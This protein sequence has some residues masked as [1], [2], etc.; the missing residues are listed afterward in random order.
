MAWTTEEARQVKQIL[1]TGATTAADVKTC[2]GE[3]AD[4]RL[5]LHGRPGNG[6]SPGLITRVG[7]NETAIRNVH[8]KYRSAVVGLWGLLLVLSGA[9]LK[10]LGDYLWQ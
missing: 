2:L 4:H 6:T 5:E 7:A 8:R 3:L 10:M 1:T 9:G